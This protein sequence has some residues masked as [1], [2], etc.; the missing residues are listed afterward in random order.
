MDGSNPCRTL[1]RGEGEML[2]GLISWWLSFSQLGGL[3]IAGKLSVLSR[4]RFVL[5]G[6]IFER[7]SGRLIEVEMSMPPSIIVTSLVNKDHSVCRWKAGCLP[8][9]VLMRGHIV[10]GRRLVYRLRNDIFCVGWDFKPYSLSH[11][12][13]RLV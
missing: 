6:I 5:P 12:V 3:P 1:T 11:S 8:P 10:A 2:S 4:P 7:T 13:S 9:S